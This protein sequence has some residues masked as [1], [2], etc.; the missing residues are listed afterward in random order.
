[1]THLLARSLQSLTADCSVL[2]NQ[3][4]HMTLN[5]QSNA[6]TLMPIMREAMR[7]AGIAAATAAMGVGT[8][9]AQ[10]TPT[11]PAPMPAAT[12]A[13]AAGGN[14]ATFKRAD[15]DGDGFISKS[16]L[17]KADAILA[18]TFN[19]YDADKDGKL[20]TVEFDAM[21]KGVRHG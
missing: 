4:I 2:R 19:K 13:P 20:S 5:D 11:Q 12:K 10:M 6:S 18:R 17:E 1:M 15:A 21:I 8:A 3:R 9:S 7:R 14:D 16:E